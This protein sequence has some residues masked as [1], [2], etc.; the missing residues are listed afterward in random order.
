EAEGRRATADAAVAAL[1][2]KAAVRAGDRLDLPQQRALLEA[3]ERVEQ[4]QTCPHGRPTMLQL[5]HEALDRAFGRP[6]RGRRRQ[7]AQ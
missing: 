5:G 6:E 7:G 1:A 3:L 2:C 4:P